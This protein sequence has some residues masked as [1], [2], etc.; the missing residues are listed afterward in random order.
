MEAIK[1]RFPGTD[2]ADLLLGV[3]EHGVGRRG[4]DP[5]AISRVD[6]LEE[7]R[8]R[9]CLDRRGIWMTVGDRTS[10]V[11]VNGRPV[12]RIAML[13]IGDSVYIEGIE[14]VLVADDSL[15]LVA[16]T[17]IDLPAQTADDPR[18]VLRGVGGRHYGRSFTLDKPRV[19]GRSPDA[20]IR[21]DDTAFSDRHAR[22][23][24]HGDQVV[25]RDL[26]SA[27]GSFVNGQRVRDALLQPGDQLVFHA[28]HRFIVEAPGR[29]QP[30]AA[31]PPP[32]AESPSDAT[33]GASLRT[34]RRLPW[35]LLA[36]LLIAAALSALLLFGSSS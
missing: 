26:D 16:A 27:E 32:A 9:L 19:V 4:D 10:G 12:R 21:I 8:V 13:R 33:P 3:G 6:D 29:V 5:G 22:I 18:I 24:L 30:A 20:D 15:A 1:L 2:A 17:L 28:H 11:H 14:I 31:A 23:E 7:A 25:L 34:A 36:A 35:L